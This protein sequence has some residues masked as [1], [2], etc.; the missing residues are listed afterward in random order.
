M[1]WHFH[2]YLHLSLITDGWLILHT[3]FISNLVSSWRCIIRY[4]N[5]TSGWV[6]PYS[7]K[8]AIVRNGDI[9]IGWGCRSTI[10]LVI[11]KYGYFVASV[12]CR[13]RV[14]IGLY[15]RCPFY[16]LDFSYITLYCTA[17]ACYLYPVVERTY[18]IG[19]RLIA[20]TIIPYLFC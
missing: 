12:Y 17:I 5:L 3:D 8:A 18:S 20:W 1:V 15:G 19:R 2:G 16:Y 14:V 9:H 10:D 13:I 6:Y 7:C 4:H 11:A